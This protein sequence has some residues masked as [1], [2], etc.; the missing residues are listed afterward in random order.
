MIRYTRFKFCP[1][2]ASPSLTVY[3]A[4]GIIC[5]SCGY[6]YFHNMAAAVA[7]IVETDG[8]IVL[9]QRGHEPRKGFFVL[10]GGFVD[11]R[12]SL[13]GA[14]VRELRE[15]IGVDVTDVRYFGSL[16]NTYDYEGVTY[17]TADAFFLCRPVDIATLKISDENT[18]VVLAEPGKI[19]LETI[20]FSPMAVM[21]ERY[22]ECA[23]K[24]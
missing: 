14:L 15:E 13:E 12:E 3:N 24:F 22:R 6:V 2:C 21:I 17:F 11:Y 7:G 4:N 16:P 1:R 9:I 10:P 8:K 20:A 19:D 5:S 23:G 18:D